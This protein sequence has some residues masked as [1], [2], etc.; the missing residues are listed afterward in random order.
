MGEIME[1]LAPVG[2]EKQLQAAIA[3]KA[4]AIYLGSDKFSARAGA[5]NFSLEDIG[6]VCLRCHHEG[7]KVYLAVNTLF[8]EDE[9][10]DAL[11]TCIDFINE[12]V[13]AVIIQDFGLLNLLE[14]YYPEIEKH[15]STQM[16]IHN[17]E[18]AK[19]VKNKGISRVVLARELSLDEIRDIS[20]AGIETEVFIHG[21]ICISY[22]G[23]CLFSSLN[24]G[25]SANRGRCA[26]PCRKPYK[27]MKAGIEVDS[28]YL[29]SPR[30]RSYIHD[31]KKLADIGV[32]SF[33]IEGRLRNENYVFEAVRQYKN[34]LDGK[35]YSIE[36]LGQI[37]KRGEFSNT[38]LE[39]TPSA[40]FI[41][42]KGGSNTG[43]FL[44]KINNGKLTLKTDLELGDGVKSGVGGFIVTKILLDK[45]QVK[46]ARTGDT[47]V[48]FPNKYKEGD[49]LYKTASQNQK[50]SIE[51]AINNYAPVQKTVNVNIEFAVGKPM[52]IYTGK[53]EITGKIVEKAIKKPLNPEKIIS[54]IEKS[55]SPF[56][57]LKVDK[58]YI[59]DG[60]MSISAIN[61]LRRTFLH[62]LEDKYIKGARKIAKQIINRKYK[63]E[64]SDHIKLVI[65]NK[66]YHINAFNYDVTVCI[67]PFSSGEG[68]I[69][70]DELQEIDKMGH[71]YYVKVPTI[72]RGE[73]DK[74]CKLLSPLNNMIGIVTANL[75]IISVFEDKL[76]IIG[77]YD[78][79]VMNSESA[80]FFDKLKYIMPSP[81]LSKTDLS[82]IK[83]KS[84]LM[85]LV[86]GNI[87][88]MNMEYSPI[89]KSEKNMDEYYLEEK[90]GKSRIHTDAFGRVTLTSYN[91]LNHSNRL[92]EYME[93]GYDNFAI[94]L[95]QEEKDITSILSKFSHNHGFGK[96]N[97]VNYKSGV[98]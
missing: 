4:D 17:V 61:I 95:N 23:Q 67:N 30:D 3:A 48:L 72:V 83:N 98:K 28:G 50:K 57:K 12:G 5:E 82:M 63:Q 74:V 75:G 86:Y 33:K 94:E 35:K 6:D 62:L 29:I 18:G 2:G 46:S 53:E 96:E 32:T 64:Q 10:M 20:S 27:L 78:L 90:N 81:E 9:I 41:T 1:I 71:K 7:I 43:L 24:G 69:D 44:G 14:K 15:A 89:N 91:P 55:S 76:D 60:F 38:Y 8:K 13:D 36:K 84:Q 73:F 16:S 54:N 66:K 92:K 49:L 47:V 70:Y 11:S 34:A 79:N 39:S 45:E 19:Y 56:I 93:M 88:Y 87:K 97:T 40:E 51:Q 77:Y 52:K 25:R 42:K 22:S 80:S 59:E 31:M 68:A 26:Q 65:I 37:F 85:P 21:A 58:P